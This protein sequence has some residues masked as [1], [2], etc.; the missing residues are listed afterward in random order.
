MSPGRRSQRSRSQRSA[1]RRAWVSGDCA[2]SSYCETRTVPIARGRLPVLLVMPSSVRVQ[3]VPAPCASITA[4]E[5]LTVLGVSLAAQGSSAACNTRCG[6]RP[7]WCGSMSRALRSCG[8]V[9]WSVAEVAAGAARTACGVSRDDRNRPRTHEPN[10]RPAERPRQTGARHNPVPM[11]TARLRPAVILC[12]GR[13]TRLRGGTRSI[14]TPL[15]EIAGRPIPWHVAQRHGDC[16]RR[17]RRQ[18]PD[19][20]ARPTHRGPGPG[21]DVPRDLCPRSRGQRLDAVGA[22]HQAHGTLAR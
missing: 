19:R 13:G 15:V 12:G 7:T 6:G 3:G 5:P 4:T 14:P 22:Y 17:H 8:S 16:V 18:H 1:I 10:L 11:S 21:L 9:L 2:S 20:R